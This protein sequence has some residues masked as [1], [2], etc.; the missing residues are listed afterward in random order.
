M[1]LPWSKVIFLFCVSQNQRSAQSISIE[2]VRIRVKRGN[3]DGFNPSQQ[4]P[5]KDIEPVICQFCIYLGKMGRPL[6]K[7]TIIELANDLIHETEYKKTVKD[8][9]ELRKLKQTETLSEAWYRGFLQRYS[10]EL[11]RS[12]IKIKDVKRNT[13]VTKENF[14]N[15]YENIYETMV[16]AGIA[17]KV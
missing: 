3:L 2:T 4:S 8:C 14:S 12:G 13:W 7:S 5:I 9:K 1:Y 11:T 17:E 16:E 6:T 10:D 15:M